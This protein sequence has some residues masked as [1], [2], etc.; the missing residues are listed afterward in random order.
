[1]P[2]ISGVDEICVDEENKIVTTP[3]FM[4]NGSF[5]EIHDGVVKMVKKVVEMI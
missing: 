5:F 2:Q 3:A 1:M 4:F